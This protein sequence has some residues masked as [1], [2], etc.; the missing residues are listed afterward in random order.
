MYTGTIAIAVAP[1]NRVEMIRRHIMSTDHKDDGYDVIF[2]WTRKCPKT[3]RIIRA[4][5][6]PFPIKVKRSK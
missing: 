5:G 3:G 6:R 1:V 2:R 4:K